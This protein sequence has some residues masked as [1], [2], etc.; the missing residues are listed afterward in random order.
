M[1]EML[2]NAKRE[3]GFQLKFWGDLVSSFCD[4]AQGTDPQMRYQVLLAGFRNKE[5]KTALATSM[6]NTI[7]QTVMLRL[8]KSKHIPVE[9]DSE[10][11]DD[12]EAKPGSESNMMQQMM[13]MMQ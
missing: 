11:A 3:K 6:V 9:E 10:F 4:A 13:T 12:D 1:I 5:W 7:Q 8:Y 2:K